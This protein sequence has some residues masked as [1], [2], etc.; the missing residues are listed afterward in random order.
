MLGQPVEKTKGPLGETR[1]VIA[2]FE[3]GP[4][5]VERDLVVAHEAGQARVVP[6]PPVTYQ[7]CPA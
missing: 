6:V 4:G 1:L 7:S 2:A 5:L 3:V